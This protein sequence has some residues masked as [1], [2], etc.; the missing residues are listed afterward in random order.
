MIYQT[1][2]A[3]SEGF[4]DRY[5]RRC[6]RIGYPSIPDCN[7]ERGKPTTASCAEST[8]CAGDVGFPEHD[9]GILKED[10]AN[11][12]RSGLASPQ[13]ELEGDIDE[14]YGGSEMG[15]ELENRFRKLIEATPRPRRQSANKVKNMAPPVAERKFGSNLSSNGSRSP[16]DRMSMRSDAGHAG[17]STNGSPS[18]SV[19]MNTSIRFRSSTLPS[20]FRKGTF[21]NSV[22]SNSS[23]GGGGGGNGGGANGGGNKGS[24]SSSPGHTRNHS[25]S[26]SKKMNNNMDADSR[27]RT[28]SSTEHARRP[29]PSRFPWE[30]R[31]AANAEEDSE[32]NEGA[33]QD[34]TYEPSTSLGARSHGRHGSSSE[35]SDLASNRGGTSMGSRSVQNVEQVHRDSGPTFSRGSYGASSAGGREDLESTIVQGKK[36]SGVSEDGIANLKSPGAA[37]PSAHT[38]SSKRR[39]QW[40]TGGLSASCGAA[41]SSESASSNNNALLSSSVGGA[42][43]RRLDRL[44][45]MRSKMEEK[46]LREMRRGST[47][48]SDSVVAVQNSGAVG[49]GAAGNAIDQEDSSNSSEVAGVTNASVA[50]AELTSVPGAGNTPSI[51]FSS[52]RDLNRGHAASFR[53]RTSTFGSGSGK[54]GSTTKSHPIQ[55][56]D[57]YVALIGSNGAV[58]TADTLDVT[59]C[60]ALSYGSRLSPKSGA[61]R[62][63]STIEA[64]ERAS[65]QGN[66]FQTSSSITSDREHA[67]SLAMDPRDT[68]ETDTSVFLEGLSEAD[69]QGPYASSPIVAEDINASLLSLSRPNFTPN[70]SSCLRELQGDL[71][72]ADNTLPQSSIVFSP[73]S[74]KSMPQSPSTNDNGPAKPAGQSKLSQCTTR[75]SV[76]NATHEGECVAKAHNMH[77]EGS[78]YLNIIEIPEDRPQGASLLKSEN[79]P[80]DSTMKFNTEDHNKDEHH[81]Q[82]YLAE[83]FPL[84]VRERSDVGQSASE[85]VMAHAFE[86]P[87]RQSQSRL[88]H[89]EQLGEYVTSD[90]SLLDSSLD[91]GT[92][93]RIIHSFYERNGGESADISGSVDEGDGEGSRMLNVSMM[94][95][96]GISH[97]DI[98]LGDIPESFSD[99]SIR[100]ES[101]ELESNDAVEVEDEE[102]TQGI[103][104][105]KDEEDNFKEDVMVVRSMGSEAEESLFPNQH[106][107][108]EFV[109]GGSNYTHDQHYD[110]L[111]S[112]GYA[113]PRGSQG[114]VAT[115]ISSI[116]NM[117]GRNPAS[118]AAVPPVRGSLAWTDGASDDHSVRGHRVSDGEAVQGVR[119]H[120]EASGRPSCISTNSFDTKL[121]VPHDWDL[122]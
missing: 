85:N 117:G 31:V 65:S 15:L 12:S 112:L 5:P 106:V 72:S 44:H 107:G 97:L 74:P 47:G 49:S 46:R 21:S 61:W 90:S 79:A 29:S 22:V 60:E 9:L 52:Q 114:T 63:S 10:Y 2:Y 56:K 103:G 80:L 13:E 96:G 33:P 1:L 42:G 24:G 120:G 68:V 11:A 27:H 70:E 69:Q 53:D 102:N 77:G 16:N 115:L 75:D 58:I 35:Q 14:L 118:Y 7:S 59:P 30:G 64:D 36:L 81:E 34:E 39:S 4:E 55:R 121:P 78:V 28:K 3:E 98:S 43:R 91:A 71:P 109:D 94:T 19:N 50:N 32:L 113:Y 89:V 119:D 67:I 86:V 116:P 82:G 38:H 51:G 25:L 87:H 92:V 62:T 122:V 18:Q 108:E 6:S 40:V 105:A 26:F 37:G 57:S 83:S 104:E 111:S 110:N 93:P 88:E 41:N 20:R 23:G 100:A 8:A 76:I 54:D 66:Q 73:I 95:E 99:Y 17:A 84:I 48:Y 45:T 101:D